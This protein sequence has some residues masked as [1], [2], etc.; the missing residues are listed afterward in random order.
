MAELIVQMGCWRMDLQIPP[1]P[2]IPGCCIG[3]LPF[4]PPDGE[5]GI[6]V[7][8]EPNRAAQN[9]VPLRLDGLCRVCKAVRFLTYL[10]GEHRV[11]PTHAA[12][13]TLY[14]AGR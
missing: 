14:I 9:F 10:L 3:P 12:P 5:I 6:R 1:T 8:S 2:L 4:R 11:P 13:K 7:L